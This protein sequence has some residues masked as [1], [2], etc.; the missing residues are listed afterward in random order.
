MNSEKPAW[1]ERAAERLF[2]VTTMAIA[3]LYYRIVESDDRATLAQ[4][5]AYDAAAREQPSRG[6]I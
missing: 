5:R 2:D 3:F 4:V 1:A 6:G